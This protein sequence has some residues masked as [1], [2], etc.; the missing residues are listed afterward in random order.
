M[1]ASAGLREG[2]QVHSMLSSS[3]ACQRL[4]NSGSCLTFSHSHATWHQPCNFKSLVCSIKG[5]GAAP[6][7][8]PGR[9][10]AAAAPASA[11]AGPSSGVAAAAA[12]AAGGSGQEGAASQ[13]GIAAGGTDGSALP[14]D[15]LT[16]IFQQA[17]K[18]GALPTAAACEL[19]GQKQ[20]WESSWAL[21]VKKHGF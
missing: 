7:K 16:L 10:I 18:Q 17:C 21:F 19:I 15:V 2:L 3:M 1:R 9:G 14:P 20:Q 13:Q 11:G 4:L 12:A 5:R 8:R 6:A